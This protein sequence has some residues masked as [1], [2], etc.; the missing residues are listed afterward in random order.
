MAEAARHDIG[1]TSAI[2]SVEQGLADPNVRHRALPVRDLT[3]LKVQ[4]AKTPLPGLY[5]AL[6]AGAPL[7]SGHQGVGEADGRRGCEVDF[8]S[9]DARQHRARLA[10]EADFHRVDS[11]SAQ[12]P[13]AV[14]AGDH[15]HPGLPSL[16]AEW[17]GADVARG[18]FVS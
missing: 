6:A 17:A 12:D 8:A 18:P 4:V 10:D 11:R 7:V 3:K 15:P 1:Q 14:G 16:D 2:Y 5:V 13:I 9:Q